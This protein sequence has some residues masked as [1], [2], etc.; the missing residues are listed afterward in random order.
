MSPG[1]RY[2]VYVYIY[3]AYICNLKISSHHGSLAQVR[4]KVETQLQTLILQLHRR[5]R[6]PCLDP[7]KWQLTYIVSA[8]LFKAHLL[9]AST[10]DGSGYLSSKFNN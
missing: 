7:H 3:I 9:T 4:Y 2:I 5:L 10:D 8:I 6:P 1:H